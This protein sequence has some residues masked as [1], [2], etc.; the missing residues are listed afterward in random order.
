M[1]WARVRGSL[2]GAQV[3]EKKARQHPAIAAIAGSRMRDFTGKSYPSAL[4]ATIPTEL[5]P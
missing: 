2:E 5:G 3:V 4:H 1:A